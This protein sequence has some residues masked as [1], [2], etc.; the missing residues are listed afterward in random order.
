[1]EEVQVTLDICK[2]KVKEVLLKK[3][4]IEIN[5][6]NSIT[7]PVDIK[8]GD[9]FGHLERLN[10]DEEFKKISDIYEKLNS[11]ES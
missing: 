3:Y 6:D 9:T 4:N 2:K 11:L 1:M 7:F 5:D 10:E 8:G